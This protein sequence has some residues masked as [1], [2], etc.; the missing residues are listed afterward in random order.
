MLQDIPLAHEGLPGLDPVHG[1]LPGLDREAAPESLLAV[2]ETLRRQIAR[3]ERELSDALLTAWEMRAQLSAGQSAGE[4]RLLGVAELERVRDTLVQ[5]LA[6][7][8]REI[9]RTAE[10]Q[11]AKR[12]LLERVL[13]EPGRYR[14]VRITREEL[15]EPD[16]GAWEVRPR[17]GLIGMLMGWWQVKLSSGCPLPG[18]RGSD[19]RPEPR[20]LGLSGV[21]C[22]YE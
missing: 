16:C 14:F 4:A 20:E 11:A 18:G 5:R 15:G 21:T 17:L 19:P 2:R 6:E 3:L 7:A 13:L 9:G 8:R 1:G 12:V 10:R 22:P